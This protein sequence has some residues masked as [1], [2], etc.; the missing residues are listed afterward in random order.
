MERVRIGRYETYAPLG[1]GGMG[2][3]YKGRDPLMERW[4]AIKTITVQDERQRARFQQEVRAAGRLNHPHI[5]TIYDVGAEGELAYIVMELV[6][7]GTL[8]GRLASPVPWVEAVNLLLPVCRALAY[9]HS[10]KVIHRDVKP[11]NILISNE[12]QVKLTDFGVARL[13]AARRLTTSNST[14]G[15]PLY[16]APEQIRSEA[17]DGRADLF[18]L[19]IVLF[20]LITGQHPFSGET[21][22]QVV[23]RLTQPEPANLKPLAVLAPPA[24]VEA[25]ACALNKDPAARFSNAEAMTSALAACLTQPTSTS[26]SP[27]LAPSQSPRLEYVASELFLSPAEEKLLRTAFAGHDRL[28]LEREFKGGYSGSRVLLATPMRSGRRL[29]K[30]V[31]K[32]DAPAA[33]ER[34]WRAYQEFVADTLPPLAARIS[35]PPV[36][37]RETQLALLWY[38]FAGEIGQAAP[39]SLREYYARHSGEAVANLLRKGVFETFGRHWWQQ[40]KTDSFILRRQYDRLLP[41]HLVVQ[42]RPRAKGTP[43][44]LVAG[45]VNI[46]HCR[47]LQAGQVVNLQGFTMAEVGNKGQTIIL[48]ALPPSK[49]RTNPIRVRVE[50]P[51]AEQAGGPVGEVLPSL[52]GVVTA[53]RH[54]LLL[55]LAQ[56]AFPNQDLGQKKL[57]IGKQA[58]PNPLFDYDILMNQLLFTMTS[59]IHGDLNLE[60]ILVTAEMNLAWLI[61]FA[62]TRQGHTLTDFMRLETQVITKLLPPIG[63]GPVEAARLMAALDRGEALSG[64]QGKKLKKPF[65][66]LTSIRQMVRT[67]LNDRQSWDEYYLG[68]VIT[69]LGALKFKE[70]DTSTRRLTLAAAAAVR[71]LIKMP[72]LRMTNEFPVSRPQRRSKRF[73]RAIGAVGLVILISLG[74]WLWGQSRHPNGTTFSTEPT[75]LITTPSATPTQPPTTTPTP[76]PTLSPPPPTSRLSGPGV[77]VG[78]LNIYSGPGLDYPPIGVVPDGNKVQVTGRSANGKWRQIAYPGGPGGYGWI[79]TEFVVMQETFTPSLATALPPPTATDTPTITPTPSSTAT[80]TPTATPTSTP[81]PLPPTPR[82]GPTGYWPSEIFERPWE[83]MGEG[84]GP[85]GYPVAPSITDRNYA[86]EYFQWGFMFWWES[87]QKPHP[88]WVIP[89]ADRSDNSGEKWMQF[90]D[91]WDGNKPLYACP[92]AGP[93][94]GPQS[95]FGLVWCQQP[96]VKELIGFPREKEF[97]SGGVG[98]RGEVQFF[99]HGI[100]LQNPANREI[101]TLINNGGWRRFN[102]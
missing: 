43:R 18:S 36:H 71:G 26:P 100:M 48:Q 14:V 89:M 8:A 99:Q 62:A 54:D 55:Q 78:P 1:Q 25:A 46:T 7:G 16:T 11:A 73:A 21:L 70:L 52:I 87:L 83:Q 56:P 69:L 61:D 98:Q 42:S 27:L 82:N 75:V 72:N 9:A 28:Y 79:L 59:I 32:L 58:Y 3:V 53:T 49:S 5:V 64:R 85:L 97:G 66:V 51:T 101:W 86:K 47:V 37:A 92:E 33:I 65:E 23:Y 20:E 24:L 67:C 90:E 45:E 50:N 77:V 31:L 2:V 19:G 35:Q 57:I 84:D 95:G 39:E 93:P 13:E 60:N 81:S 17:L 34:E 80:P 30:V 38:T 15:T 29:T 22:A 12:G 76:S 63:V 4:V 44:P 10:Q 102:Y 96:G 74:L 40:R 91:L 88:I 6:E 41:V 68:L 94:D